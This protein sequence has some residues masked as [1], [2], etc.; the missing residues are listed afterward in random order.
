MI[1][2]SRSTSSSIISKSDTSQ[3]TKNVNSKL[4]PKIRLKQIQENSS[5]DTSEKF[6][7]AGKLRLKSLKDLMPLDENTTEKSNCKTSFETD[8]LEISHV[9]TTTKT[10]DIIYDEQKIMEKTTENDAMK[11]E[12]PQ[13]IE[14]LEQPAGNRLRFR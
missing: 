5:K 13:Y 14:I 10:S 3:D 2:I 12:M 8:D 11:D 1:I 6:E 7:K 9:E 4:P